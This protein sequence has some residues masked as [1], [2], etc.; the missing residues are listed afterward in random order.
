MT[1]QIVSSLRNVQVVTVLAQV[2]NIFSLIT[3]RNIRCNDCTLCTD[4]T[5]Q[6][7]YTCEHECNSVEDCKDDYCSTAVGYKCK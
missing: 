3:F 5:L 6:L 2:W 7:G 4:V 1:H